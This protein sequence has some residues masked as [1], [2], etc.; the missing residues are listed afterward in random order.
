MTARLRSWT[1]AALLVGG[2]QAG[3][4]EAQR[5]SPS[6]VARGVTVG[7]RPRPDFDPLGVRLNGFRLDAGLSTGLGWDSN[8]FGRR[9]NVVSDG[10]AEEAL[11]V[12]I[13]SD[14]STHAL[15]ASGRFGARQYFSRSD[16]DWQDFNIGAYGRYDLG[17]FSSVGARYRHYREH[18]DVYN[19][20]V[21]S[22]G[23]SRPVPVDSDEF[24]VDGNTRFN[25]LGLQANALYRTYRFS[26]VSLA[27]VPVRA[28]LN[29]FD[30]AAGVIGANYEIAPGR[31]INAYVRLQ[32]ISYTN[33]ASRGRDSFTYEGLIGFQ[34]DFDGV[35]QGRI[36]LGWR[37]RDYRSAAL[38]PLEGLAA[39]G[40]LIWLP[41]QLTTVTFTVARTIEESIRRDAVS[42]TRTQGGIAVDHEFLRNVILGADARVDSRSYPRPA[43]T[44]TD[45][46]FTL[47]ARYL[48]NRNMSLHGS[49][50]FSTR[51]EATGG[52]TE[53]DRNLL[54]VRLRF[55]L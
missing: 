42:F 9:R 40:Q 36:A 19:F 12:S 21:Q 51:L 18:L 27:G 50:Q 26:D 34:Y 47:S 8:V 53:Y 4:A 2:I 43:Q 25:R 3:T 45:G 16:L 54:L 1:A 28:S 29:D 5:L 32:D 7:S 11:D 41:T 6:D 30:T 13:N 37:H 39:E 10:Y 31:Y 33:S 24:Y 55:D 44:A 17:E 23:I 35:W 38:K 14:W 48:L 15:G 49:Y 52:A 46:V 22:A 20:D